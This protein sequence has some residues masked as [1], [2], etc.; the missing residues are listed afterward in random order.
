MAELIDIFASID[1]NKIK[2]ETDDKNDYEN[3]TFDFGLDETE[4]SGLYFIPEGDERLVDK[5]NFNFKKL[6]PN[7]INVTDNYTS[8]D[9][10]F[11]L[12]DTTGSVDPIII[13]LTASPNNNLIQILDIKNNFSTKNVILSSNLNI[14]GSSNNYNLNIN[15]KNYQILLVDNDWRVF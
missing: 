11:L 3:N 1:A 14:M 15:N 6:A 10:D 8:K 4:N 2:R 12:C 9:G 7:Y 5:I 13:T